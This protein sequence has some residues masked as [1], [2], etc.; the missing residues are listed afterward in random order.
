MFLGPSMVRDARLPAASPR[1]GFGT[2]SQL[3]RPIQGHP[4]VM[5]YQS[6]AP[7]GRQ[8]GLEEYLKAIKSHKFLL[9]ALTA[10]SLLVAAW[11]SQTRTLEYVAESKVLIGPSPIGAVNEFALRPPVLEREREVIVSTPLV[12]PAAATIGADTEDVIRDLEVT[13]IPNSEVINIAYPNSVPETAAALVNALASGY[14][15]QREGQAISL[16]E[17]RLAVYQERVTSLTQ[18]HDQVSATIA[19]L[20]LQR[21][22]LARQTLN[23][24]ISAQIAAVDGSIASAREDAGVLR[25]SL[26]TAEQE[27]DGVSTAL[28]AREPAASVLLEAPVPDEATGLSAPLVLLLGLIV[29]LTL[30]VVAAL[31]A[32]RL[33][34]TAKDETAIALALGAS[35]LGSIPA[36]PWG[37]RQGG[38]ALVMLSSG[39]KGKLQRPR[40]AYRRLRSSVRFATGTTGEGTRR[41][42]AAIML[43]SAFPGEGKSVT[44][45][46]LSIALAQSGLKVVLVNA[47]LRRP[48]IERLFGLPNEKGLSNY[49]LGSGEPVTYEVEGVDSFVVVPAGPPPESPAELL[50]S[51]RMR[52]LVKYLRSEADLVVI[53]CPPIMSTADPLVVSQWTDGAVVVVDS[54]TTDTPDLLRVRA[55]LE[56]S[57]AKILG[58]VLNRDRRR[59][60][61]RFRLR[62]WYSDNYSA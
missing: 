30:G 22:A 3:A 25:G 12:G 56:K 1:A 13:F 50:G 31:V 41:E 19:E 38:A 32:D 54:Q 34:H 57:G 61:G 9:G 40:E 44:S 7:Q 37:N 62:G 39:A 18:Q 11:F 46:N 60:G 17:D 14:V 29:G 43:T 55:E 16:L 8:V 6:G 42:G 4:V 36:L 20:Q 15:Q 48:S 59:H 23:A 33:D 53:D 21:A 2:K 35:A 49:L 45:A 52:D 28:R 47:D 51:N 24:D 58:A 5:M 27:A 10:L 26:R